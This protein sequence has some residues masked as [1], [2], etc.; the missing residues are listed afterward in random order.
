MTT[1]GL[2]KLNILISSYLP[3]Y[4]SKS[5]GLILILKYLK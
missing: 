4:V 2:Y 5:L 3:Y 1:I